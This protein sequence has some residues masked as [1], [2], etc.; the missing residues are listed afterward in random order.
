MEPQKP[1]TP[2]GNLRKRNKARGITIPDFKIYYKA[3]VI[4][5][6]WY[7]HKKSTEQSR[8]P[9]NK[10]TLKWSINL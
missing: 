1:Q 10:T 6:V 4:K 7:L 5:T 8:V 9:R 3:I 2:K